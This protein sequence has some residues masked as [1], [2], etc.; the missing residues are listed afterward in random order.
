MGNGRV[1]RKGRESLPAWAGFSQEIVLCDDDVQA[2]DIALSLVA[3]LRLAALAVARSRRGF[4]SEG[5]L[6]IGPAWCSGMATGPESPHAHVLLA[7]D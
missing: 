4:D 7:W 6:W 2:I 5:R 3:E 1:E